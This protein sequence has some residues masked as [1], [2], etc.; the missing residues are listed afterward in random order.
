MHLGPDAA[1]YWH[2]AAKGR[3]PRPFNLRWLLPQLCGHNQLRWWIAWFA[4]WLLVAGGMFGWRFAVGDPWTVA[5]AATA[6][7][8][9]LPGILGPP[10]TI[11]VGVDIPSTGV[12]LCSIALFEVGWWWL[13][14]PVMFVAAGIRET[15]PVWAALWLWSPLP[16][17]ALAVPVVA[18]FAVPTGRDPL[19]ERFQEIADHPIRTALAAHRG[20]W[21][22]GWLMIAPWGTCLAALYAPTWPLV[23]VLVLAYTQLLVATDTVR[24][25]QHAAG[26]AMAVAAAQVIPL[27]WLL[28]A[29]VVHVAWWR[30][31]ERV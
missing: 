10:G 14:V 27:E 2:A 19:G 20:R 3:V 1:R 6:L 12:A 24:L 26:P 29:V 22:D 17:V 7:L 25:V 13:A 9:A 21:R 16:L 8:V 18:Q 5:A 4:G 11:P 23:A 15:A 28:P 31:P 30:T